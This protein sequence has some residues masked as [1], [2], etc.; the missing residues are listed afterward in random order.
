MAARSLL[1]AAYGPAAAVMRDW[2]CYRW[3]TIFGG[4]VAFALACA[5]GAN[6]VAASFGTSIGSGALSMTQATVMASLMEFIG[7]TVMGDRN[8]DSMQFN[9]ILRERPPDAGLFMWGLFIAIIAATVCLAFATYLELPVSSTL[10]VI[11]GIIGMALTARGLQAIYWNGRPDGYK[12]AGNIGGVLEIILSW[13][14]APLIAAVASFLFF[15]FTKMIFLRS[16]HAGKRILQFMPVYYGLTV[17]V[18]IF[19]VIYKGASRSSLHDWPAGRAALIAGLSGILATLLA[20]V[21]VVPLVHKQLRATNKDSAVSEEPTQPIA[22]AVAP[23]KEAPPGPQDH[24]TQQQEQ[25]MSPEEMI[26]QFNQLRVL[27]TVYEGEDEGNASPDVSVRCSP[28]CGPGKLSFG[29]LLARTPNRHRT[30]KRIRRPKKLTAR[31]KVLKFLHRIKSATISHKIDYDRDVIVRHA[32]AEK[33]DDKVEELFSFLQVLTACVASFAHG[34]NDVAAI[35]GPYAAVVQI[36][37]HRPDVPNRDI[38]VWILAMAGIGVSLGFALFGWKLSR[39]LG[40]RLTFMTPSRGYSAQFCALATILFASRTELPVSTTHVVVG[41]IV[42]VGAA[43]NIKNVNWK[44]AMAFVM[45]W[46]ATLVSACGIAAALYS[47][48]VFSPAYTVA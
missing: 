40:G 20:F 1:Q 42:G 15:G 44:L 8:L 46:I 32:L 4:F 2:D 39:C 5:A 3:I 14:L 18:L 12:L 22:I 7:A 37:N 24:S 9:L 30:F 29:Q 16:E 6:D 27:D 33:F 21:I 43:D 25:D 45:A 13:F 17:M 23:E 35:M 47:F 38:D 31:Q 10:A 48:T 11:G 36:F 26:K 28:M 41:A 19:F 34:S